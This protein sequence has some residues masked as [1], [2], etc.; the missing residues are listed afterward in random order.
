MF[1]NL[2]QVSAAPFRVDDLLALAVV[3]IAIWGCGIHF[4][5]EIIF[6]RRGQR[7]NMIFEQIERYDKI[8]I[9]IHWLFLAFMAGL[10]VTGLIIYKMDY[11]SE[12]SPQI[13]AVSL[14]NW[15]AYHWYFAIA[16]L[17]IGLFHIVYDSIIIRKFGDAWVTRLDLRNMKIITRN[18]FA[19]TK[20]YPQLAKLH[21]MQKM[22]HWSLFAVVFLLGFTGL[23]AWE[24]LNSLL[25]SA[26]PGFTDWLD[27][28]QSRYLHD[29]L[30]FAL[31]SLVIGHFYFSTLIPTNWKVFRG[32]V[33]G[34]LKYPAK[35]NQSA[36]SPKK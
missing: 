4:I 2:L 30:T 33:Y 34:R 11:L 27:I 6:G 5:R 7:W 21:P 19:L 24:P 10:F 36:E 12:I 1:S 32:I 25:Q 23:T 28:H 26:G 22:F 3:S 14:R 20:E 13:A 35:K 9:V 15:V 8:Q 18:F 17:D 31:V 29:L 16:V